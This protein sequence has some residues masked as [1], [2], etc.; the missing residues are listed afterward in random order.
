MYH[1]LCYDIFV[2]DFLHILWCMDEWDKDKTDDHEE[3]PSEDFLWTHHEARVDTCWID[4]CMSEGSDIFSYPDD[5]GDEEESECEIHRV[6]FV[7]RPDI[8]G[9]L[10][11]DD[12]DDCKNNISKIP[13][14]MVCEEIHIDCDG[15]KNGIYFFRITIIT[16]LQD[17][18][19]TSDIAADGRVHESCK[20]WNMHDPDGEFSGIWPWSDRR[21][22]LED[23]HHSG[24]DMKEYDHPD[25]LPWLELFP[26]QKYLKKNRHQKEEIISI[27]QSLQRII[28]FR[29]DD[30]D[31]EKYPKNTRVCLLVDKDEEVMKE[32]SHD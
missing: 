20:E 25:F 24:N 1:F 5:D 19:D 9:C 14:K 3:E 30:H 7:Q 10:S 23:F 13:D 27:E 2:C 29:H 4:P 18:P 28:I 17:S 22:R 12:E 8:Y 26:D 21:M 32:R 16:K 11:E 15:D 31:D 6:V